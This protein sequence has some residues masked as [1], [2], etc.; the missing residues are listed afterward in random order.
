MIAAV[1]AWGASRLT[2]E[3]AVEDRFRFILGV[4]CDRDTSRCPDDRYFASAGLVDDRVDW[5]GIDR[6]G[7][8]GL[9]LEAILL[10]IRHFQPDS[11][12]QYSGVSS[13]NLSQLEQKEFASRDFDK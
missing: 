10:G 4:S 13:R 8:D 1:L 12:E 11:P 6:C 3:C 5:R 2:F 7:V 9:V